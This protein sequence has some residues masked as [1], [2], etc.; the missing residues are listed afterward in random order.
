MLVVAA[1]VYTQV[2][3]TFMP[4]M[5]EGDIIVGIEKLPSVSLEETAALDLKIQQ[6]LMRAC[7]K[8]PASSRAPAPTRSA[9]TR[10][11]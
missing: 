11:A 8:S 5:D 3:K 7:R 4:T 10:W 2:G 1:G 9:S 6:A